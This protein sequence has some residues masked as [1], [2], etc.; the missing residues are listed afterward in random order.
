MPILNRN[1][2]ISETFIANDHKAANTNRR[3]QALP[4]KFAAANIKLYVHD[5]VASMSSGIVLLECKEQ[6]V[7]VWVLGNSIMW[8]YVVY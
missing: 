7:C 2:K 6:T 8:K 5:T 1:S 3:L 4:T